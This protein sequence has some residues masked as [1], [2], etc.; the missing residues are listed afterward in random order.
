[1]SQR[2]WSDWFLLAEASACVYLRSG[3]P[4]FACEASH[5]RAATQGRLFEKSSCG[6]EGMA[7]WRRAE[8]DVQPLDGGCAEDAATLAE[9]Q[10]RLAATDLARWD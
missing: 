9:S 8:T 1:M 10:C 3:F 2:A 5:H 7:S 4:R 6:P